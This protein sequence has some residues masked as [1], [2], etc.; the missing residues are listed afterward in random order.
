L[1]AKKHGAL[2]GQ[3]LLAEITAARERLENIEARLRATYAPQPLPLSS[4]LE[5][6]A[7]A[8]Y[9]SRLARGAFLPELELV[10]PAWDMMLALYIAQQDGRA[11][12]LSDAFSYAR[13]APSTGRRWVDKLMA[14]GLIDRVQVPGD[15]RLVLLRLSETGTERMERLLQTLSES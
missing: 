3:G 4:E 13:I 12:T 5:K 9:E 10:E 15:R 11:V 8:L 1:T 2:D 6:V 7:R 14:A